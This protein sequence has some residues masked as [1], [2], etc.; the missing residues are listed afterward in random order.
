MSNH[1]R[2]VDNRPRIDKIDKMRGS[3][4]VAMKAA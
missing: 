1:A 2:V 4:V 3:N